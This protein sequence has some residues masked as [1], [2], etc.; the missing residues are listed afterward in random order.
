MQSLD[1]YDDQKVGRKSVLS[2]QEKPTALAA[3]KIFEQPSSEGY[4]LG[5]G[6][7]DAPQSDIMAPGSASI[8]KG[9]GSEAGGN[10]LNASVPMFQKPRTQ[11]YVPPKSQTDG[12]K[13]RT[14][15][16]NDTGSRTHIRQSATSIPQAAEE[17]DAGKPKPKDDLLSD[18]APNVVG[19]QVLPK[20]M[21]SAPADVVVD[22]AING[23]QA[24]SIGS[25]S[26]EEQ[27]EQQ[28]VE[29]NRDK[30]AAEMQRERNRALLLQFMK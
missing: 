24:D 15:I 28:R 21:P 4:D 25:S 18:Y 20:A 14:K 3:N 30:S 26:E 6:G 23:E 27:A 1:P 29:A 5:Q 19:S 17:L 13:V 8:I 2:E 16:I 7:F 11:D 9:A 10:Q 12:K 22:H